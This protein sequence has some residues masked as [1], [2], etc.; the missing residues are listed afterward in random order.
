MPR[1]N[2]YCFSMFLSSVKLVP[3][4]PTRLFSFSF[5]HF[6]PQHARCRLRTKSVHGRPLCE[7]RFIVV[8]AETQKFIR[9][10]EKW[11]A[12]AHPKRS[13]PPPTTGGH[14]PSGK[15]VDERLADS[16]PGGRVAVRIM[17]EPQQP[18]GEG[19]LIL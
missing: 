8:G 1:L 19:R 10:E 9:A 16:E 3:F 17:P 5:H 14:G 15:W 2:R 11:R 4:T 18:R 13:D 6:I 12:L 7:I